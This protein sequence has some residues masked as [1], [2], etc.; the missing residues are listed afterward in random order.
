MLVGVA[1]QFQVPVFLI[2]YFSANGETCA[3]HRAVFIDGASELAL[4]W[5]SFIPKLL[6]AQ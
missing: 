5:S 6:T 4:G 1:F 2:F 3:R